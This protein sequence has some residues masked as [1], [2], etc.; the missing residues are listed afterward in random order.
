MTIIRKV[1]ELCVILGIILASG[2]EEKD[3][4]QRR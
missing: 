2:R 1:T 3:T 4:D